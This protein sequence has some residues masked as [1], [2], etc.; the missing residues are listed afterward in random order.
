MNLLLSRLAL[1]STLLISGAATAANNLIPIKFI[2]TPSLSKST[3]TQENALSI[4]RQT[5]EQKHINLTNDG[6]YLKAMVKVNHSLKKEDPFIIVYLLDKKIFAYQSIKISLNQQNQ[7]THVEM[8]YQSKA[9]TPPSNS[10]P[11]QCPDNSVNFIT[12]S[13]LYSEMSV[14]KNAVDE[15]YEQA[16][17][18]GY[19]PYKLID[20]AASVENYQNWLACPNLKGFAHVGHGSETAIMLNDGDL[21]ANMI[22]QNVKLNKKVIVAFNSCL[23]F[24]D[25]L[26]PA[27]TDHALAQRFSGGI[28]SLLIQGSTQTYSCMWKAMLATGT[29]M[30]QALEDCKKSFDPSI[31]NTNSP[32]YIIN[33]AYD[34]NFFDPDKNYPVYAI[35]SKGRT[36][37]QSKLY[38]S[39]DINLDAD[40]ALT[41]I[42]IVND[43]NKHVQCKGF[44]TTSGRHGALFSVGFKLEGKEHP[45][46]NKNECSMYN[47]LEENGLPYVDE[48]GLGGLGSDYLSR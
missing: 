12:A 6:P 26:K 4:T 17:K 36:F 46:T 18:S 16:K 11:H 13:P 15:E 41:D 5:L 47:A 25:P 43:E 35:T 32:I 31:P 9:L 40:E 30:S 3:L 14:V 33:S 42:Y 45:T 20:E 44:P 34:Y 38:E 1:A 8:N 39:L 23:V 2:Q 27:M 7:P 29:A 21:D 37:V 24:N 48:Y 10:T 19:T 28:N 22:K